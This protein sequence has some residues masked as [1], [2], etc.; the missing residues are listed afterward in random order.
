MSLTNDE[1]KKNIL[2][3]IEIELEEAVEGVYFSQIIITNY[4]SKRAENAESN[5]TRGIKCASALKSGSNVEAVAVAPA[6]TT[7]I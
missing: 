1:I 3:Q 2:K 5:K 4:Q 7:Y 6:P